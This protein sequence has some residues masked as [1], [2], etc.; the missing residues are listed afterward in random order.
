MSTKEKSYSSVTKCL[1]CGNS[2][3]MEFVAEYS[4]SENQ[5]IEET[6]QLITSGYEYQLL[7][8]EACKNVTLRRFFDADYFDN[9]DY[10]L[11]I[12]Y[13]QENKLPNAL[14]PKVM[15]S[16]QAATKVRNIDAN[17]YAVLLGRVLEI[18]CQDRNAAGDTLYKKLEDLSNKG[19]IPKP[20]AE[21]AHSLR[22]LRNVGAHADLGDLTKK[23]IPFLDDLC[24]AVLEYVYS[25]PELVE[26]AKKRLE[27]ISKSPQP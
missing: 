26:K 20:L 12:L 4:Q 25:A 1:H 8:C 18:I 14:P 3:R 24:R 17:A 6:E 23:E 22:Q 9:D 16:Y 5:F 13:P 11:E 27:E 2:S 21:M 15:T 19:E 7:L 10:V